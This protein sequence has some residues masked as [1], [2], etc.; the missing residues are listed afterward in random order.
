MSSTWISFD[1]SA[2]SFG[3]SVGWMHVYVL[4]RRRMQYW[5]L[6][7][8]R[9][10]FGKRPMMSLGIRFSC[11]HLDR[12]GWNDLIL[13]CRGASSTLMQEIAQG[14]VDFSHLAEFEHLIWAR[15]FNLW[16]FFPL[17]WWMKFRW[18][19][20][21]VIVNSLTRSCRVSMDGSWIKKQDSGVRYTRSL[22][23]F[24]PQALIFTVWWIGITT[25]GIPDQTWF[26]TSSGWCEIAY[27]H[28]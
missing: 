3:F 25:I 23:F 21:L 12:S 13:I 5:I 7:K 10:R 26:R 14:W 11:R 20:R 17:H 27:K 16:V 18:A 15:T 8:W 1:S 2:C 24:H 28:A 6:V 9:Q 4:Y 19:G 22:S